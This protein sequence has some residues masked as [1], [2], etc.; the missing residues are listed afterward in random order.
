MVTAKKTF[1]IDAIHSDTSPNKTDSA[2]SVQKT[3]EPQP[4][5]S[6]DRIGNKFEAEPKVQPINKQHSPRNDGDQMQNG[7]SKF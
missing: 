5:L 3:E 2:I 4:Q 1:S 6:D 7:M